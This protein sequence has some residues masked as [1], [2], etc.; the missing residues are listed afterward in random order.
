MNARI[1]RRKS[2]KK[3]STNTI[4]ECFCQ[5]LIR[6]QVQTCRLA[7]IIYALWL[8]Y[9]SSLCFCLFLLL[10]ALAVPV[11]RGQVRA[12]AVGCLCTG[13]RER[14]REGTLVIG[15]DSQLLTERLI[16]RLKK[17]K[18]NPSANLPKRVNR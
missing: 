14:E 15:D 11:A 5:Y 17:K 7:W 2:F 6:Q 4:C 3:Q 9:V 16:D 10:D 13:E 12:V 18:L 1:R 8:R